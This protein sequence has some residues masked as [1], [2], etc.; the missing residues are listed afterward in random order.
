M[1]KF[2]KYLFVFPIIFA[3]SC[4]NS[5]NNLY[6]KSEYSNEE[7]YSLLSSFY[8]GYHVKGEL[9][10]KSIY[11]DEEYSSYNSETIYSIS[12]DYGYL[13]KGDSKYKA[14]KNYL[15]DSVS[16][17]YKGDKNKV[18]GDYL[19]YK[20]EVISEIS[21]L[22]L[23]APYFDSKYLDPF[24]YI[25]YKDF[26]SSFV[27]NNNKAS[28]LLEEYFGVSVN[29]SEAK[30]SVSEKGIEANFT[31][32]SNTCLLETSSNETGYVYYDLAY[33]LSLI[34]TFDNVE[35]SELTPSRE[36]NTDLDKAFNNLSDNYTFV[37]S[38]SEA[39]STIGFF[40][41]EEGILEVGNYYQTS[42]T[43]GDYYYKKSGD[44]YT[45]YEYNPG[46]LSDFVKVK[47]GV[48]FDE[49]LVDFSTIS[50][51][52][53]TKISEN[54]YILLDE[55]ST[56]VPYYL[57]PIAY[58]FNE[59]DG[60]SGSITLDSNKRL[61]SINLSFYY[62]G[63]YI[64]YNQNIIDYSSTSFPSYFDSSIDDFA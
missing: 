52:V 33:D 20:N 60:V 51:A 50:S 41:T 28:F 9:K 25:T 24:D 40:V 22:G 39:S 56:Y 23:S 15:E 1:K 7:I 8:K 47:D 61:S 34:F 44:S 10:E 37:L 19:N 59:D 48:R 13:V 31:I 14:I 49:I 45:Q 54:T 42:L 63:E 27:L 6:N 16:T 11:E 36:V 4:S 64:N 2:I 38:S 46:L 30:F 21:S 58:R 32:A 26:S 55:A 3:F 53:F 35:F 5:E 62:G 29:V 57:T 12:R 43:S 18:Y 17:Y